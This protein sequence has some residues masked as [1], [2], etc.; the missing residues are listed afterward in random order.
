MKPL[1]CQCC[2]GAKGF[3]H[4]GDCLNCGGTGIESCECGA[5][6]DAWHWIIDSEV[7]DHAQLLPT[8][9]GC[10]DQYVTQGRVLAVRP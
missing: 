1:E 3:D 8:C 6:A 10:H 9:H 4:P 2:L 7:T 5:N